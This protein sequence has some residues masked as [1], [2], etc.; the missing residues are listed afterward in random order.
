[1]HRPRRAI[2]FVL[3]AVAILFLS[4][5]SALPQVGPAW[6]AAPVSA[7][8]PTSPAKPSHPPPASGGATPFS[9]AAFPH[10]RPVDPSKLFHVP[11]PRP[12][13]WR[14][15]TVPPGAPL[16]SGLGPSFGHFPVGSAQP[17]I[18]S[19][20]LN[21]ECYGVWPSVGGQ[22]IYLPTCYGHDEPGLDPYSTLP[23]SGGNVSWN[24]TLPVDRSPTQNQSDL[25]SAIWFGMTLTDPLGW[26]DQCFLELQFYPDSSFS[27]IGAT[28]NGL[29]SAAAVAWQIDAT[30]G[31]EDP[32]Y[33]ADLTVSGSGA[34]FFQ[35]TQGDRV[36][37]NMTGWQHSRWG[38]NISV[39]DATTKSSS[40]VNLVDPTGNFPLNPAYLA[41]D[42]PNSLQWTPGGELPVAFSFETGH[43][44]NP[45]FPQNNS[46]GGCSPG[47]PPPTP[48][49]GAVPCPSYDPG[50]WSNDTLAPW[51]IQ[52]PVFFNA[53][54]RA[55]AAQ[56]GFTQDL[57]GIA[58]TNGTSGV[59]STGS[60]GCSNRLGTAYC[61]Y[62]WYSYSCLWHA[63]E[64]GATAYPETSAD[65]G[66][67]L[68]Y[69]A[70]VE[71][72]GLGLAY[73]PPSNASVPACAGPFASLTLGVPAT[74][75]TG[76]IAFL[77]DQVTSGTILAGLGLGNYSIQAI[78]LGSARFQKWVT[79]GGAR[80]A[81]VLDPW[82]S[83][84][85]TGSGGVH[86]MFA[87]S[88]PQVKLTFYSQPTYGNLS[89][90]PGL[91]SLTGGLA[92]PRALT[93]TN[94]Q[95]V[96]LDTGLYS[97]GAYAPQKRNFSAWTTPGGPSWVAAPQFPFTWLDLNGSGSVN[98]T[99]TFVNSGSV[100]TVYIT[101]FI[102]GNMTI[103]G[104]M[105]SGTSGAY[106]SLNVG[107]Y[108]IVALP[109]TGVL[110]YSW[111]WRGSVLVSNFNATTFVTFEVGFSSISPDFYAS[112]PVTINTS[113]AAAGAVSFNGSAPA[114]V[115]LVHV[116]WT[117]MGGALVTGLSALPT[118]KYS[119][120]VNW[121]TKDPSNVSFDLPNA[122][123]CRLFLQF[124]SGPPE[125]QFITG[126]FAVRSAGLN[127]TVHTTPAL[128]ASFSV[129]NGSLLPDGGS[130]S[131]LG[132]GV[133]D[134]RVFPA[135]GRSFVN[136][137]TTGSASVL[138][139]SPG[140]SSA[141]LLLVNVNS[142]GAGG[143][144]D[145]FVTLR[146]LPP[147]RWNVTFVADSPVGATATL[148]SSVVGVDGTTVLTNGSYPLSVALGPNETLGSW[149]TAGGLAVTSSSGASTLHVAG[150][151]TVY[152]LTNP[153]SEVVLSGIRLLF[154]TSALLTRNQLN[155][156]AVPSC[157]GGMKCPAV[158]LSWAL[159][160]ASLGSLSSS[161]GSS[162]TFTAG[163]HPGRLNITVTGALNGGYWSTT[164]QVTIR[165]RIAGVQLSPPGASVLIGDTRSLL[166]SEYC[167]DLVRCV[168][169]A[170]FSWSLG[171]ASLGTLDT[172]T[173][174]VVTFTPNQLPGNET[175][176]VRAEMF[177]DAVFGS[178]LLS[179]RFA[180]LVSL[181]LTPSVTTILAGRSVVLSGSTACENA[182]PCPGGTTFA[183]NETG[184]YAS[185]SLNS[186][187]GASVSFVASNV[188]GTVSISVAATLNG[189]TL[190]SLPAL[191][192]VVFFTTLVSAAI[193]P[194]AGQLQP[195]RMAQLSLRVNCTPLPCPSG[196]HVE[197][198]VT[199][200]TD[201]VLTTSANSGPTGLAPTQ[202]QFTSN[203][204][205]GT[206]RLFANVSWNNSV[207][208]ATPATITIAGGPA[209]SGIVGSLSNPWVWV[210]VALVVAVAIVV[211]L[212][213]WVRKPPSS[214]PL[215]ERP[216]TTGAV[217]PV[218]AA[219]KPPA[220]D[221]D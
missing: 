123:V 86:A 148:N 147:F 135:T 191:V 17:G 29:W 139:A 46:F 137:S 115:Q 155:L 149:S 116:P 81:S 39:V 11:G 187:S 165:P 134:V 56:V 154:T 50:S 45:G 43:A 143:R 131:Y 98:L 49:N 96:T 21:A 2:S 23:G 31:V 140:G 175:V 97:I 141:E 110:P 69:N 124:F 25:Y 68:E 219:E 107:T 67:Y 6:A 152:A 178:A 28:A 158:N 101:P 194:V 166:A 122:P 89:I 9:P 169:N 174:P 82:T 221:G 156:S 163:N 32:C 162:V 180:A 74:A 133:H 47:V 215:E 119:S 108:P 150:P 62:P 167:Q 7:H 77:T 200:M 170:N 213:V 1:M 186:S 24:V 3:A 198:S 208:E 127:L 126:H 60:F 120:F 182:L 102:G 20:L 144:A 19:P 93:L 22:S 132:N 203:G 40:F 138:S 205:T 70:G 36:Y 53:Q 12:Q 176:S 55:P 220:V 33:Y 83:L 79:S 16:P 26:M 105:V 109:A 212:V 160:P 188:P 179:I 136:G 207:V 177:G 118:G 18:T 80:V 72:N 129:D 201:G 5:F 185:G 54:T 206:V 57:G 181:A 61:S 42:Y 92:D 66:K 94:G 193:V 100:A 15:A 99:A 51:R 146:L 161:N 88:A 48:F 30:Y 153:R 145:L 130:A 104:T 10:A 157:V 75:P 73:Y 90:A 113:V 121:S 190:R 192:N 216:P 217:A 128:T 95:N 171:D 65:F 44:G 103:G 35:M 168:A 91:G 164:T 173:G 38:E 76:R 202:A 142:P 34:T 41:S 59:F 184:S 211:L 218:A 63:F 52:T 112:V 37:V 117:T 27:V 106:L 214:E 71:Y 195:G 159:A 204:T 199:P 58:F 183:W 4:S 197:W 84:S 111:T 14:G 196:I 125:P 210:G 64:F 151:G 172:T 189:A 78:P 87:L 85:L 13:S 114:S 8:S 209:S